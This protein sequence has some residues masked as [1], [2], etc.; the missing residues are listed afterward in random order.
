[1]NTKQVSK[2]KKWQY[3]LSA[4]MVEQLFSMPNCYTRAVRK[5]VEHPLQHCHALLKAIGQ[6]RVLEE[7][8]SRKI[9]VIHQ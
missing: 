7:S 8:A 3:L 2:K 6:R 4:D 5:H 9:S 1:M